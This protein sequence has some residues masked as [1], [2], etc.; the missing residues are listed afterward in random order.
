MNIKALVERYVRATFARPFLW[1][2]LFVLITVASVLFGKPVI[3]TDLAELLPEDAPAVLALEEAR[4]R[5]GGGGEFLTIAVQ[6]PD[7]L[8]NARFMEAIGERLAAWPETNYV[9]L[10]RD[11]TFF[12][13]HALLF[14]PVED[15]ENIRLNVSRLVREELEQQNPLFVDLSA[16]EREERDPEWRDPSTWVD[17]MTWEELNMS[18]EQ[19]ESLFPFMDDDEAPEEPAE[20]APARPELPPEYADYHISDD[21][22]VGAVLV[23]ISASTT[24]VTEASEIFD[25]GTALIAELDPT[26]FHPEME[27]QVV[28]AFRDFLEVRKLISDVLQ[29]TFISLALVTLLLIAFFRNVRAIFV[30]SVPLLMGVAW[31]LLAMKLVFG[32]LNTLTAFIFSMLI[33]MGIDFSIHIYQ[34]ALLEFEAG[35]DWVR[36]VYLSLTRTGRALL[37]AMFTTVASLAVMVFA[38]FDGFREFGLACAMGVL[39]CLLATALVLPVMIAVAERVR[40]LPRKARAI[41]GARRSSDPDVGP[42]RY[43]T[44]FRVITVA[45][46]LLAFFGAL[47]IRDARF[48]YDFTNLSGPGSGPTIRY[49]SAL[50]SSRSTSPAVILGTSQEQMRE[51]HHRLREELREGNP[52]VEGFVTVETFVPEDQEARMAAIDRIYET[53]DRR[54]VRNIGGD[55][56]QIV[57][58]LLELTDT[59]PFEAEALPDWIRDQLTERDG[60]FGR[61]GLFYADVEWWNVLDVR[62]FQKEFAVIDVPSGEVAV[63]SSGFILDNVVRYVQADGPRLA[64]YVFIAIT[65]ILLLDLRSLLGAGLCLLTLGVAVLLTIAGMTLFGVKLGLYNMI[66]LPT[67]LGVGV[68]GAVHIY[69]R[70]LEEGRDHLWT[71]M[72]TTGSA[73]IASSATTAAGFAGLLVTSHK[74]VETIGQ[75]ALIGIFSSLIAVVGLMPGILSLIGKRRPKNPFQTASYPGI[76]VTDADFEDEQSEPEER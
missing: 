32:E 67:V 18:P 34:R 53:L 46:A 41:G 72:R 16:D 73:V 13:E 48:E 63:A 66:V 38:S 49:G 29:S 23:S 27:A 59:E 1:L 47:S 12:R 42:L 52:R 22:T 51:V 39:I 50:G 74:G 60:S 55:T 76:E 54:A 17:P 70:Y 24:D 71:V 33:G 65:L 58:T 45:V 35:E 30:V 26:S 11:R 10:E 20:V 40:P 31:S 7:A 75:L 44:T 56:G 61:L 62:R 64:L 5:R 57:E 28:G 21:G 4:E 3:K 14:L 68:D 15:L 8:A 37:T 43:V 9:E 19:V 25:R 69:H 36:A 6:S 2:G